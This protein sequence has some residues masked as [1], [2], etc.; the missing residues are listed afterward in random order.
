MDQHSSNMISLLSA[1]TF[2]LAATLVV[3]VSSQ[4]QKPMS[5]YVCTHPSYKVHMVSKSPLVVYIADFITAAER[6]HLLEM[7][8]VHIAVSA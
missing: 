1:A 6:S 3:P 5:E 7:A 8:S 2:A 4:D